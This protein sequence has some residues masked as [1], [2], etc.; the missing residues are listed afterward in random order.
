MTPVQLSIRSRLTAWY[1]FVL[2]LGLGLF[3]T[4]IWFRLEQTL[5][6][7]IDAE[8]AQRVEGLKVV[9][10]IEGENVT[11]EM[12]AGE[13][14]EF[15]QEIPDVPWMEIRDHN[16]AALLP[17]RGTL[18]FPD[19]VWA[20]PGYRTIIWRNGPVRVLTASYDD[21]GE[22]YSALVATP[23]ER[24]NAVMHGLRTLSSAIIPAVLLIAGL[25]GYWLSRRAL[26][27]VDQI[28]EVAR[29]IS[30][31]NMS[32]RLTVPNTGDELQRMSEAWNDVL[33]RL[34]SALDRIRHFTADASHELRT[35]IAL[36]RGTAELA[37]RRE[38]D[39]DEYRRALLEVQSHAERMTDL[40]D[41]LLTLAR[42]DAVGAAMPFTTVDLSD[43]V[44]ETVQ[45]M[46][47][48][49]GQKQISL[50]TRMPVESVFV[51]GN[52]T[53]IRRLLLILLDNAVK[54]TESPGRVEISI[55]KTD[56]RVEL[57]VTDFGVG[58]DASVLPHIFERFYRVDPSRGSN[59]G[60]GLGL[61]IAQMI[62]KAHGSSVEVESSLG[63][64]STFCLAFRI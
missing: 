8:L 27:P 60:V 20:S 21:R 22:H 47:A 1:A 58:M 15:A 33:E 62:A 25:G 49:A 53:A 38:R 61:P 13:L 51:Q 2:L 23:L 17:L 56:H 46:K 35:P 48:L 18:H 45:Q 5:L 42:A 29:S 3:A 19:S 64:G 31:Q 30:A 32:S 28:T 26:A 63:V 36:I 59:A 50:Q 40:T 55:S 57:A 10:H 7:D 14:D 54:Y 41:S 6:A 9:T 24:V 43:L 39:P 4:G 12:L 11:R 37:L 34:E 16:G 44:L 52:A